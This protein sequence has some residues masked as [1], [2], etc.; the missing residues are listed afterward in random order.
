[1]PAAGGPLSDRIVNHDRIAVAPLAHHTDPMILGGGG[2]LIIRESF[3]V[4]GGKEAGLSKRLEGL[5]TKSPQ[6][7][8]GPQIKF[9]TNVF[10]PLVPAADEYVVV[11]VQGLAQ[12]QQIYDIVDTFRADKLFKNF[13]YEVSVNHVLVPSPFGGAGCPYGPPFPASKYA[14]PPL[15]PTSGS[16]VVTVIDSSYQDWWH[17][18]VRTKHD[19]VFG[20]WGDNPL[21]DHCHL[22]QI[23][24]APWVQGTKP[25]LAPRDLV[26]ALSNPV[27]PITLH[28]G[29][30][31]TNLGDVP[32]AREA[33]LVD[34]LAGHANFVAGVVAQGCDYPTMEI[35]SHRGSF[36]EKSDFSFATEAAV[37]LSIVLS[38][39]QQWSTL[40]TTA[41]VIQCGFAFALR[42]KTVSVKQGKDFLSGIWTKTLK[43]VAAR[44]QAQ[45]RPFPMIVAP[46]GN[47][48]QT[49]PYFPAALYAYFH[50]NGHYYNTT[51][52]LFDHVIGVGSLGPKPDLNFHWTP[53]NRKKISHE[54]RY[55]GG[56]MMPYD[57]GPSRFTNH[58][59]WVTCSAIGEDVHSV[60][61]PLAVPT[62]KTMRRED[63]EQ[64]PRD[65]LSFPNAAAIWN[66]TS[67]AAP[68]VAAAIA[69]R[70]DAQH[71]PSAAWKMLQQMGTK[72]PANDIGLG[73][74]FD[75]L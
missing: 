68:K 17:Q 54:L 73:L 69:A 41:D 45:N 33:G 31:S 10:G 11:E 63:D 43:A 37:C 4:A 53:G 48:G 23:K 12:P 9:L 62:P 38:Q 40:P 44:C 50:E 30:N 2:Q 36:V 20:P 71:P 1:M 13:E 25:S 8:A 49:A 56:W 59:P 46:A 72:P 3:Y 18:S 21:E 29:W 51:T 32:A 28:A 47:E 42:D 35:W 5:P 70:V 66:G 34:A 7:L 26:S 67:F 57:Y 19:E 64:V 55:G 22:H 39:D 15:P 58:G 14:P 60:Y 65:H 75:N 6:K 74:R 61:M 24:H 16:P 52:S 27:A